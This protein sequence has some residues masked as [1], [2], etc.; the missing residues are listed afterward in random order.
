MSTKVA[1][2]QICNISGKADLSIMWVK[3]VTKQKKRQIKSIAGHVRSNP[4]LKAF[5]F[6]DPQL[7]WGVLISTA[8]PITVIQDGDRKEW[9][10]IGRMSDVGLE[11]QPITKNKENAEMISIHNNMNVALCRLTL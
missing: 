1:T 4:F 10:S 7:W 5:R 6:V 8:V 11:A 3:G 2:T 9:E